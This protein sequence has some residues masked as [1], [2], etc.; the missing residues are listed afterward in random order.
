MMKNCY[1]EGAI[2]CGKEKGKL[3]L[4]WK[5]TIKTCKSAQV[6]IYT[7]ATP[8]LDGRKCFVPRSGRSKCGEELPV[9]IV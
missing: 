3:F 5:H 4:N 9:P 6:Y 8:G 7:L 2:V 1:S